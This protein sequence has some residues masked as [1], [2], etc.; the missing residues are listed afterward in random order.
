[1][2]AIAYRFR[3]EL[4]VR[5]R[6]WAVLALLLGVVAAGVLTLA[7]T[8]RRTQSVQDRFLTAQLAYDAAIATE[9]EPAECHPRL[10]QLPSVAAATTVSLLNPFIATADGTSVQPDPTDA[11]YSGPGRVEV[12]YD[13]SG[14]FGN[15]INK[16]RFVAG[17]PANPS[18]PNE[19]TIS[20]ETATRLRLGPGSELRLQFMNDCV[21][22]PSAWSA[23]R[24]VQVVG[25]QTSPGEV[26]PPSGQYLQH[27]DVTPAFMQTLDPEVPG[28]PAMVVRLK[29]G[30][31]VEQFTAEARDRGYDVFPAVVMSEH[32]D[33]ITRGIRPVYVSLGL[34]AAMT[35]LAGALVLAQVLFRQALFESA[36][37]EILGSIGMR[38]RDFVMLATL[39]AAFVGLVAAIFATVVS[40]VA[41]S[42]T[43]SGLARRLEPSPGI[44]FDATAV[45]LGCG[46]LLVYTVVV[47]V[48]SATW[49]A[50]RTRRDERP[51]HSTIATV[52]ARAGLPATTVSGVGL[53]LTRGHGANAVPVVSTF[54]SLTLAVMAVVGSLT[55][56]ASLDHLRSNVE[57]VGWNWDVL[58]TSPQDETDSSTGRDEV[59]ARVQRALATHPGVV[60]AAPGLVWSPF[61]DGREL[62]LGPDQLPA[63]GFMG[64]DGSARVGPSIISGRKPSASDEILLAP[65]TLSDLGLRI[66]DEVTVVGQ[67]GSWE[68]PGSETTAEM[69][70]VGTGVVPMA[71]RLGVGAVVTIDGAA[72]LNS[73]VEDQA[74]FIRTTD[75]TSTESVVDAFMRA[76]PDADRSSVS[77]Y[78]FSDLPDPTLN[79]E[80]INAAPWLFAILM[81][82]M[83]TVVLVHAVTTTTRARRRDLAVLRAL[84]FSRGQTMRTIGWQAN[85]YLLGALAFGTPLGV[86]A[87]VLIWREYAAGLGV[88]PVAVTPWTT[89][90]IAVAVAVTLVLV[91]A[92]P[93]AWRATRLRPAAVLRNE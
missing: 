86:L 65:S 7:S 46:V 73:T 79:L 39:R 9:C 64:F 68:K 23:P 34:L 67:D 29:A 59:R 48:A 12:L 32:A 54:A 38:R 88:V 47:M 37:D 49:L 52:A 2:G 83:A 66:G 35:A 42:F 5:W 85:I 51:A 3:S 76:F 13:A 63:G 89:W 40:T 17:R 91:A 21:D 92:F 62:E 57:L 80:Q 30:A 93:A 19:V 33:A 69:R 43:L 27:L 10:A 25:V 22:D 71:E 1:M 87:G 18:A 53:A 90:L 28:N 11:C 58:A 16:Q 26:R 75:G 61:P 4:R 70:I 50:G 20:S 82:V 77:T 60:D 36:D 8:A 44:A 84:G 45:A 74:W 6:S 15:T 81:G 72:R 41:S 24:T 14:R 56:G 78:A 55:F 31:S